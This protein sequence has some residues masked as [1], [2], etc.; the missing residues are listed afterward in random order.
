M[1]CISIHQKPVSYI[2]ARLPEKTQD[3]CLPLVTRLEIEAKALGGV[4]G[5]DADRPSPSGLRFTDL[6]ANSPV[7]ATKVVVYFP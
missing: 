3:R 6:T 2:W 7:I 1:T 4:N 5:Y